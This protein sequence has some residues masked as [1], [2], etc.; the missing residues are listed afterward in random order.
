[1]KTGNRKPKIRNLKG[2]TSGIKRQL[3]QGLKSLKRAMRGAAGPTNK[4]TNWNRPAEVRA[5]WLSG[6]MGGISAHQGGQEC[7]RR[8][9]QMAEHKCINPEVWT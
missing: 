4:A 5:R 3:A 2:P 7:A 1:M 8:V 6:F 9:R